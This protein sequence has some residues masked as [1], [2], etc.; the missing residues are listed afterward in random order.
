MDKNIISPYY[1]S[2]LGLATTPHHPALF[3]SDYDSPLPVYHVSQKCISLAIHAYLA[4]IL[5]KNPETDSILVPYSSCDPQN[6][7]PKFLHHPKNIPHFLKTNPSKPTPLIYSMSLV[8]SL[9]QMA[10][11]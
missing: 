1:F 6:P 2:Y 9:S 5:T 7:S 10:S 4:L 8:H 3:A 11:G